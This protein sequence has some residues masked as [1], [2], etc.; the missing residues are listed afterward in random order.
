MTS[1]PFQTKI[2]LETL[3]DMIVKKKMT[4]EQIMK[5]T[6]IKSYTMIDKLFKLATM[7]PKQAAQFCQAVPDEISTKV[8]R[9]KSITIPSKLCDRLQIETGT[10]FDVSQNEKSGNIILTPVK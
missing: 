4:P 8:E 6:G 1:K 5:D 9:K 10:R 7:Y 3:K 2:D